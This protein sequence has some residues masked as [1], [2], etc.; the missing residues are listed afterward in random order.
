MPLA[1]IALG[2]GQVGLTAFGMAVLAKLRTTVR[3]RRWLSEDE[4]EEGLALVQLYPGP[5]MIDFTAYVG[6]RLRGMRGAL[7]ATLG[8]VTPSFVLMVALSAGYF[9]GARDA[10]MRTMVKG[11]DAIVVGVVAGVTLDFARAYAARPLAAGIAGAAFVADLYGASP[12]LVVLVALVA[13][14]LLLRPGP[15]PVAADAANRRPSRA[16]GRARRWAAVAALA[17]VVLAG[18]AL[19]AAAE[20]RPLATMGA[21]LFEIGAVAFGNGLTILPLIAHL[22]VGA[23]HWLTPAQLNA[24]IAFGQ[25]TPGPFLITAAFLGYKLGGVPGALLATAAIFAPSFAMTLGFTEAEAVLRSW[26][27]LRGALSGVMAGFVGLLAL[28][29][30][31][32]G[33]PL[34]G[35]RAGLVLAAASLVAAHAAKLDILWVFAGGLALWAAAWQL[36][37]LGLR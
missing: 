6:Y 31:D 15:G 7:A 14:G 23:H 13:G 20:P 11:L 3:E 26:R 16:A 22:S 28:V 25:V 29:V 17:A 37:L 24:G 12:I 32:L 10:W 4:V 18:G 33:R 34:L 19:L 35:D 30:L 21:G 2:F 27:P 8:F 5:I 9:A 36:G 1:S